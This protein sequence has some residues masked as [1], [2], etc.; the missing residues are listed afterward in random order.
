MP[1]PRR[2]SGS[3]SDAA[4]AEA[5]VA[6]EKPMPCSTRQIANTAVP[7]AN[8]GRI[9]PTNKNNVPP[10]ITTT[11]PTL[12]MTGPHA[13][14]ATAAEAENTAASTPAS[15][16]PW[17]MWSRYTDVP[18]LSPWPTMKLHSV[19]MMMKMNSGDHSRSVFCF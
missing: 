3:T 11:R 9:V 8:T 19:M 7:D 2:D 10:S 13:M 18:E 15:V 1:S 4:V 14:R 6:A 16:A 12:S 17:P 5:V